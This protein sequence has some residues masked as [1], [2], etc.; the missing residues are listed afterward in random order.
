[1]E[2]QRGGYL[3]DVTAITERWR[4][5]ERVD[6]QLLHEGDP[7]LWKTA[8]SQTKPQRLDC[9]G[10]LSSALGPCL[11]RSPEESEKDCPSEWV[12]PAM[13]KQIYLKLD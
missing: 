9:S 5:A 7:W 2:K 8:C 10:R 3:Y 4:R 6:A 1:M 13:R 12:G 11:G